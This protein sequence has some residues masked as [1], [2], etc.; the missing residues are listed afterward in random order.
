L[1]EIHREKY[2]IHKNKF[3]CIFTNGTYLCNLLPDQDTEHQQLP[4]GGNEPKVS[5]K[6]LNFPTMTSSTIHYPLVLPVSELQE[7][8]T[9][10]TLTASPANV[11]FVTF[12]PSFPVVEF[13]YSHWCVIFHCVH[14]P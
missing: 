12:T 14:V 1:I 4:E 7:H 2:T 3:G 8:S 10:S 9:R 6:C 13:I 11:M 5:G